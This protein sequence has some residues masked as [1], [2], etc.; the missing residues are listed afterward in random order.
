MA[1]LQGTATSVDDVLNQL[2]GFLV[3]DGWAVKRDITSFSAGNSLVVSDSPESNTVIEIASVIPKGTTNSTDW[4]SLAMRNSKAFDVNAQILGQPNGVFGVNAASQSWDATWNSSKLGYH[5]SSTLLINKSL[6]SINF[7]FF[8]D[9]TRPYIWVVMTTNSKNT[10]FSYVGAGKIDK[11]GWTDDT[12]GH[13]QTGIIAGVCYDSTTTGISLSGGS[14]ESTSYY[15]ESF[16]SFDVS[17]PFGSFSNIDYW[18]PSAGGFINITSDSTN[19]WAFAINERTWNNSGSITP[20][21][22]NQSPWNK[23]FA[24]CIMNC[25]EPYAPWRGFINYSILKDMQASLDST[26]ANFLG[27]ACS[28][29]SGVSMLLPYYLMVERAPLHSK[30]FSLIGVSP[31]MYYTSIRNLT[32]GKVFTQGQDKFVGFPFGM[33]DLSKP[34]GIANGLDLGMISSYNGFAIK[35]KS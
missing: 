31:D 24:S 7:W 11:I 1:F 32:P 22:T 30:K 15:G 16:R 3:A 4:K 33:Y 6:Q 2:K 10:Y 12:A 26:E 18:Y 21:P 23:K 27:A 28:P 29:F 5:F 14:H 13:F 9:K 34:S 25:N 19:D 8:T 17:A 35:L 20:L